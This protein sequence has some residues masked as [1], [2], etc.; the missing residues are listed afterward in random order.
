MNTLK[1][2]I[3]R[4]NKKC[5][6]LVKTAVLIT[7]FSC[8]VF[9]VRLQASGNGTATAAFLRFDQSARAI[10]MGGS[11][12]GVADNA[13][14]VYYNPAGLGQL[15]SK[16]LSV[17]YSK[18][19]QGISASNIA[20]VLPAGKAGVLGLAVTHVGFDD[21]EKMD[22]AGNSLG[23]ADVYNMAVGIYYSSNFN[24]LLMGAGVKMIKQD[25]DAVAGTGM[26]LD[27]G[28]LFKAMDNKLS[29]GA[30]VLNAGPEMK[31]GG[32]SNALPLNI[33]GGCGYKIA[34][35]ITISFDVE[36]PSDAELLLH[37][38]GEYNLGASLSLR[39]GYQTLENAGPTAG[40]G[41][42]GDIQS[43]TSDF[44]G[45][46]PS[47]SKLVMKFRIDYAYVSYSHLEATHRI[48]AGIE[49]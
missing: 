10:A 32:F 6:R 9:Q 30:S 2:I 14:A 8:M 19:Y 38:G 34:D 39:L 33:R 1:N 29:I 16:E 23:N 21:I 45:E 7:I 43:K 15:T 12:T 47:V 5:K 37:M 22:T 44:W 48:T 25:Y 31:I 27:A 42:K 35:N 49:F 13:E 26:C 28:A 36:K 46:T 11:F 3:F 24:G 41:F 4:A 20:F 17:T 40:I 18:L